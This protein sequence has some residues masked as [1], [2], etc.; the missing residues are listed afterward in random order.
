MGIVIE[1]GLSEL[2]TVLNVAACLN[3]HN[4]I[5]ELPVCSD[6]FLSIYYCK[7]LGGNSLDDTDDSLEG[8]GGCE[9]GCRIEF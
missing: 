8:H 1:I 7:T 3:A 9:K 4:K 5:Q 6:A 2:I